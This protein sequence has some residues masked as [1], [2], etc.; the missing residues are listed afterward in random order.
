MRAVPFPTLALFLALGLTGSGARAAECDGNATQTALNDCQGALFAQ[1]DA[2]L[3]ALYGQ[4]TARLAAD[5]DTKTRLT[6]AQ[7]AWLAYR[8]AECDFAASGVA[9]GSVAP[10]IRARC[11]TDLTRARSADFRRYLACAE[12]DLSCPLPPG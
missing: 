11:L 12:G 2:E 3:N 10:L 7:R 9:G 5:P 1:A 4:M 8:D 6:T